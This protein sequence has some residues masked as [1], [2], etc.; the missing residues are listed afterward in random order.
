MPVY[1]GRDYTP[2]GESKMARILLVHENGQ[3][4]QVTAFN[5][6]YDVRDGFVVVEDDPEQLGHS[7]ARDAEEICKLV[8]W[9]EV[10][11]V[12][13]PVRLFRPA[14]PKDVEAYKALTEKGKKSEPK[15]A[16]EKGK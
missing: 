7:A 14:G 5:H 11:G 13:H 3:C 12:R 16:E 4:E 2:K 15:D 1:T 8:D 10:G 6:T 9:I